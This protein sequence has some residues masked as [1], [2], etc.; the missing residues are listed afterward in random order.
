MSGCKCKISLIF[1]LVSLFSIRAFSQQLNRGDSLVL[2]DFQKVN[3]KPQLHYSLGSTFMSVQHIGSVT[4]FTLS[5]SLS[6]PITPK[7]SVE[8][9]FIAGRFY[10]TL[11][12]FN[13]EGML[14]GTFN[15][16]SVFGSASYHVN[17]Q[18]TV[19]GL[20]IKQLTSSPFSLLPTSSYAIGSTFK[21]GNSSIGVTLQMSTWNNNLSPMPFSQGFYSP[22]DQRSDILAPFGR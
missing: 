18:L 12:D 2:S 14:N 10:S 16:L 7:L 4:G 19:Y 13:P 17:S 9:G 6:V 5:P 20:G 8:G 3:L 1:I 15:E 21:F 22:Y 11:S